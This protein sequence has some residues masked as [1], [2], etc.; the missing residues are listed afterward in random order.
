MF[1]CRTLKLSEV[2]IKVEV[3]TKLQPLLYES[4][5]FVLFSE[6]INLFKSPV[7]R[8]IRLSSLLLSQKR[9]FLALFNCLFFVVPHLSMS[10]VTTDTLYALE[11][12]HNK[13]KFKKL[14]TFC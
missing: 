12:T 9:N 4:S 1:I 3:A 5:N 11:E 10:S 7:T 13:S 8:L 6:L 14:P 2:T